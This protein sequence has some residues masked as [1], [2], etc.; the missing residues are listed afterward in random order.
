MH[1]DRCDVFVIVIKIQIIVDALD[2]A[3]NTL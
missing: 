1:N 3:K 2:L